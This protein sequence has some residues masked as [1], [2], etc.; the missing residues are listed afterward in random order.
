MLLD[1]LSRI[2]DFCIKFEASV[3]YVFGLGERTSIRSCIVVV[4]SLN[5]RAGG[6]LNQPGQEGR[7]IYSS[8]TV[9]L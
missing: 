1:I 9:L 4:L 2:A 3:V 5:V 6:D 8:C 7:G